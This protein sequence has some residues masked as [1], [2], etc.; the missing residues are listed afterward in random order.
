MRE[1]HSHAGR[2]KNITQVMNVSINTT[3]LPGTDM[4]FTFFL[5]LFLSSSRSA[6]DK[7]FFPFL[8]CHCMLLCLVVTT[9]DDNLNFPSFSYSSKLKTFAFYYVKLSFTY[10]IG[11]KGKNFIKICKK[12]ENY[13]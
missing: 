3:Q 10:D 9:C 7:I 4:R 2:E 12:K 1:I 13:F 8:L 6:C 11:K 5:F